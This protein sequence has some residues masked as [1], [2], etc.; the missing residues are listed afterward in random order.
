MMDA[1]SSGS[2]PRFD[3]EGWPIDTFILRFYDTTPYN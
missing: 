3:R 1:R 2:M